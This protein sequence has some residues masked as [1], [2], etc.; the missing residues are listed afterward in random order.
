MQAPRYPR[1][2]R[3]LHRGQALLPQR[4]GAMERG[5]SLA[6]LPRGS[7]GTIEAAQH[8]SLWEQS[9]LAMQAPRYPRRPRHLHRGQALLPQRDGAMERGASLAALPR[10]S[11]GTIEAAQHKSLWEQSLL[12]IQAPRYP[13]RPC[14]LHRGQALLPQRDGAMERGASLA[15][16]PRGSVGTIEAAQHKSI[17]EQSLLTMQAPRYPRRPRH[18]HRGQALLPQRDGAMERGA[19]LAA[20]PR[21]SVGTIEA[22]QHKSLWEQ[23]LLAMQAPRFPRR[24]RHLH[25]G[26][27]LLPQRDGAMERGAS[28]AALPRGSVGTI[29]A[30]QHKS[31]WEQSLLAIQAPR[32][33][34][35]PCHLHRGQAL[36]PQRD[37]A[38]ER[39]ASLA[40][41]PRGS[42]G[43]IEAAQHKSIWEQS[44]LT[45]QAPRY[46]R[47][48]RHLHRGQALLPQRDGAMERGASLAALPRGS[49]GTIEAAQHKSMW[50]QSLLAM[51][52]PRFPRRPRHL[53]RGQALLPQ[54]DGAMFR[55]F[56]KWAA[57]YRPAN[58]MIIRDNR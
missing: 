50:E 11:V 12:A 45:M 47:R 7:V 31:L 30:A 29:E 40:A 42:V 13:R 20:L 54:R 39:G 34:R 6:A 58:S 37:G 23:S 35:R 36:L 1:R 4:D 28:L 15:A 51:Q 46:P 19:S 38:M 14:H 56:K 44:L 22:A 16:L 17:W 27:A 41:L 10:G 2:P 18:L 49:V 55:S 25:R 57:R 3:H 26:Q 33:P 43:T 9:L 48:P 21:G 5:A 53:H 52:A 32:Y 24:P 8:K